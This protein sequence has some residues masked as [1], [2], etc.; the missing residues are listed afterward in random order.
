MGV[1]D[2]GTQVPSQA[3]ASGEGFLEEVMPAAMIGHDS[4]EQ[5]VSL[6]SSCRE[7]RLPGAIVSRG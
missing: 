3:V 5:W 2:A 1:E 6:G 7:L 4:Q